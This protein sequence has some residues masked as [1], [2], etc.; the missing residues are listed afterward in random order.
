MVG[1]LSEEQPDPPGLQGQHR[2]R[3]VVQFVLVEAEQLLARVGRD[4]L[5]HPLPGVGL[6]REPGALDRLAHPAVHHRDVQHVLVQR[7]DG[8][9]ADEVVL[10]GR[11]AVDV[12]LGDR[13]V[14]RVHRAE[15]PA[16]L[17]RLAD[18]QHLAG[19]DVRRVVERPVRA[20]AARQES[21]ASLRVAE[22]AERLGV[23]VAEPAGSEEREVPVGQPAQQPC[24]VLDGGRGEG[25]R[26]VDE[27]VGDIPC[28]VAHRRSVL[29]DQ[30]HLGEDVQQLLLQSGPVGVRVGG[31]PLRRPPE[32]EAH[33][34][35]GDRTR[36]RR[37][38]VGVAEQLLQGAVL[39]AAHRDDRMEQPSNRPG[40]PLGRGRDRLDEERHVICHD[41]DDVG[42]WPGP[43]LYPN[44]GDTGHPPLGELP[45][46]PDSVDQ[47]F[48]GLLGQ[49]L[50]RR[51]PE[52]QSEQRGQL[53]RD[54]GATPRLRGRH[55]SQPSVP[56]ARFLASEAGKPT[57]LVR[58]PVSVGG[59]RSSDGGLASGQ[60]AGS[61][62][63]VSPGLAC[64]GSDGV[65]W[66]P[67][68]RAAR[69][70]SARRPRSCPRTR[71][72]GPGR[73]RCPPRPE[74]A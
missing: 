36:R 54:S 52:V 65:A 21:A 37:G 69:S 3:Y 45:V 11:L 32:H 17:A 31:Q 27:R 18:D 57:S 51:V 63:S 72:S 74:C 73:R 33:P 6:Q 46:R 15:H 26:D 70:C 14:E 40:D 2:E 67:P 60:R 7:A 35:L 29:D 13:D 25:R 28:P 64:G 62:M 5:E 53:R 30:S 61:E 56:S 16:G 47:L 58:T 39:G 20:G 59:P 34:R 49:V 68:P 9:H 19:W 44:Q 1:V 50:L 48:R 10:P 38:R 43:G 12:E 42:P 66:R 41:L 23:R 4:H 55:P 8:E 71:T 22:H 24:A